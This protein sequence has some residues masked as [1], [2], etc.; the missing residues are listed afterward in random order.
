MK[1]IWWRVG[2]S[3]ASPIHRRAS[4][5]CRRCESALSH[6]STLIA[7]LRWVVVVNLRF[8]WP[9]SRAHWDSRCAK[10]T[11]CTVI[12]VCAPWFG[13]LP[14][15]TVAFS[16]ATKFW[17]L[18][19]FQF[20]IWPM[21][22]LWYFWGRRPK[23]CACG[24]GAIQTMSRTVRRPALKR[25]TQSGRFFGPKQSIYSQKSLIGNK[26]LWAMTPQIRPWN[27]PAHRQRESDD[28]SAA[29]RPLKLHIKDFSITRAS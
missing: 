18:I 7:S 16:R 4:H 9:S 29:P 26:I 1:F 19:V 13:S 27:R 5:R 3:W 8:C 15:R 23:W 17:P 24:C 20:L 21:S 11:M 14:F 6:W 12:T 10:T 22:R 2:R 28:F 25:V